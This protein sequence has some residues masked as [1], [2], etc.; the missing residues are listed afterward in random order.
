M[1]ADKPVHIVADWFISHVDRS[2]TI[3]CIAKISR[4]TI[5]HHC[6]HRENA[7]ALLALHYAWKRCRPQFSAS[8]S[9]RTRRF[10]ANA[11]PEPLN[12]EIGGQW[13]CLLAELP[14]L[15]IEGA[16]KF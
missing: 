3:H 7:V 6:L 15:G 4:S 12:Y 2:K 9:P 5:Y 13:L 14:N 16:A 1:E 8:I 10:V 11:S